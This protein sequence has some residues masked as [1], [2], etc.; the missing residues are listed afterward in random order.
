MC[1]SVKNEQ[2]LVRQAQAGEECAFEE[3]VSIYETKIYHMALRYTGDPQEAM[4]ICQEVFLRMFRSIGKFE[5]NS[6]FSTWIYRIADNACKDALRRSGSRR[7]ISL[8][9]QDEEE[10]YQLEI[11]DLRYNPE[12]VYDRAAMREAIVDGISALP[13][14][15]R[16]ILILRDVNG[17]TYEQIG[18]C[19]DLEMGTVKSRIAR[20]REKLRSF[21]SSGWNKSEKSASK[22]TKGGSRS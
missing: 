18:E 11:P 17:L 22:E 5:G 10:Q 15:L 20:S 4:D 9:Q 14:N 6:S 7:T 2:E 16:E 1:E 19:L 8:D 3:L 13:E 12:S 21:L